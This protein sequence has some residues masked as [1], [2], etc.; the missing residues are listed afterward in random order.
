[1]F[2]VAEALGGEDFDRNFAAEAEVA[3][4][5]DLTEPT[6]PE[7]SQDFVG[8]ELRTDGQRHAATEGGESIS[9]FTRFVATIRTGSPS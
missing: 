9:G 1:V 4:S 3:G 5:I 7:R 2:V 6:G 8:P